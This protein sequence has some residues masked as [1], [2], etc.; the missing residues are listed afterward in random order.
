MTDHS[1]IHEVLRCCHNCN[2]L[3]N[4]LNQSIMCVK[5]HKREKELLVF[6]GKSSLIWPKTLFCPISLLLWV[7]LPQIFSLICGIQ[8]M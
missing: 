2:R 5:A 7:R 3:V 6:K 1:H 4:E 8:V